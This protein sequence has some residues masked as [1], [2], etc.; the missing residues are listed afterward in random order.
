MD[1]KL[2][3]FVSSTYKDLKN[4]RQKAVEGILKARHIP[5]GME[6]FIPTDK[7]QWEIIQEWIKDSDVLLLILGGRYGSVEP[8]SQKS[9]TQ[10][11]YE[12][13]LANDIP[14]FSIVLNDQF[15]A[16]KKSADISV[17]IYEYEI[18]NAAIEQYKEFKNKV[19]S[20]YAQSV[21]TIDQISTE[22]TLAL[23]NFI[24]RDSSDYQFRGWIRGVEKLDPIKY[25]WERN[26]NRYLDEKKRK[27]RT[28][29]TIDS[30]TGDFKILSNFF[31]DKNAWDINIEDMRKFFIY[32]EDNY[33]LKERSSL[34]K[35]R[36][37][38]NGLFEWMVKEKIIDLN[39][40]KEIDSYYYY[41]KEKD[42]LTEAEIQRLRKEGAN[43][44]DRAIIE[45]LL[46]TGC[47]LSEISKIDRKDIDWVNNTVSLTSSKGDKRI[48]FLTEQ[49]E[50]SIKQYIQSRNDQVN[51]LLVTER[52]PYREI[53]PDAIA[54]VVRKVAN[55][56]ALN[57][58]ISP[59][60]FRNT[61]ATILEEQGYPLNIIESLL[62]YHPR[63]NRAEVYVKITSRNIW[64]VLKKRPDF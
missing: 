47:H 49:A 8:N 29:V 31:K 25:S 50:K 51:F 3:V 56:A 26:I 10:L 59:R 36:G 28:Q 60:T 62:G 1:K 48:G 5:A 21:E 63:K 4:E 61:Y 13:A 19:F 35:I 11:E 18:E 45:I 23:Q 32:R 46:S 42:I 24:A 17:Q 2:Q 52:R 41:R 37:V 34:E 6:L 9:Y 64:N 14:V 38:I 16:N 39:P 27:G 20:N 43:L 57:R 33:P 40:V 44:R 30:Y 53:S 7:T 12:F 58:P 22:V 55:K 54:M 15:L